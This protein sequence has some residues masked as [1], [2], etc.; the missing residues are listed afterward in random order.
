M[1]YITGDTHNTEDMSNLSSMNMKLCCMEQNSDF[2]AITAAI[3]LGDFGLPWN[4]DCTID[5]SGIHPTDHTDRYLLKWYNQKPFKILAVM[6]N[7]DNYDVIEKLLEVEMFGS[8]VLKVSDNVFYLKRGVIYTIDDKRFLVLGG[9]LSDDKAWRKPHE[10]W[11]KQEEW[12]EAEKA[13]CLE[14]IEQCGSS[15]DF[16][17]SH[18]GPSAGIALTDVFF[19]NEENVKLLQRDSNV[20]F[21]DQIDSIIR[22][23]KWFFGHWHS[24]WG[25]EHYNESKY[26]PLYHQGIVI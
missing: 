26:I 17:L 13:D 12:S 11:W 10:S 9:A 21:N 24:D 14:K 22:Y 20:I 6:G 19:N 4:S 16:V 3:V 25:Y 23:K 7:H 5:E 2:H 8:K 1:I 15:F 18:T